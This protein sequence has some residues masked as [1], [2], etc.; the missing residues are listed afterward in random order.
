MKQPTM[1]TRTNQFLGT[2]VNNIEITTDY[3]QI[4][5]QSRRYSSGRL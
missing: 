1:K 5:P 3:Y 4:E 2:I